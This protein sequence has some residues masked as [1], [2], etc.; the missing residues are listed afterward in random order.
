MGPAPRGT[1]TALIHLWVACAAFACSPGALLHAGTQPAADIG[2]RPG[3]SATPVSCLASS[4]QMTGF[5]WLVRLI[6]CQ[7]PTQAG[8]STCQICLLVA[9][10]RCPGTP[11]CPNGSG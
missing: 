8:H 2:N 7:G 5:S 4:N 1:A 10:I 11:R 3:P 9:G 6:G